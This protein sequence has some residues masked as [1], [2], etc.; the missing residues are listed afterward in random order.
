MI[1]EKAVPLVAQQEPRGT[2]DGKA[3][4]NPEPMPIVT[5]LPPD[6]KVLRDFIK[7]RHI[8]LIDLLEVVQTI[9]PRC[10]KS[11]LSKC[12]HGE[13]TGARLRDDAMKALTVHFREDGQTATV[14]P[15]RKKQHRIQCRVG[16]AV[17]EALQRRLKQAGQNTQDYLEALIL[18]DLQTHREE[19]K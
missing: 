3:N 19:L 10:D 11:L 7:R 6:V 18:A 1:N 17:Y 9:Y 14:R 16:D 4:Q 2:E 5:K 13:E 8:P 15:A 12:A